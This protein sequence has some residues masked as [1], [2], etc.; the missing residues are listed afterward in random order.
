LRNIHV[1]NELAVGGAFKT[2]LGAFPASVLV[3]LSADQHEMRRR[4]AHSRTGHHE[5]EMLW[6]DMLAPETGDA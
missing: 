4:S 3:M 5:A 6:L 2:Y 1:T